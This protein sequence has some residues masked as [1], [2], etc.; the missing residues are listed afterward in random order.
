MLNRRKSI[1]CMIII[2]MVLSMGTP[3]LALDDKEQNLSIDDF[4][5][6]GPLELT[7]QSDGSFKESAVYEI[8]YDDNGTERVSNGSKIS[9]I[10]GSGASYFDISYDKKSIICIN[11]DQVTDNT[12]IDISMI[13]DETTWGALKQN[14]RIIKEATVDNPFIVETNL[15]NDTFYM[16]VDGASFGIYLSNPKTEHYMKVPDAAKISIEGIA[17]DDIE[18]QDGYKD[19]IY[20]TIEIK[21]I[22]NRGEYTLK[23]DLTEVDGFGYVVEKKMICNIPENA[24]LVK[25]DSQSISLGRGDTLKFKI[26]ATDGDGKI[27]DVPSDISFIIKKDNGDGDV[28]DSNLYEITDLGDSLYSIQIKDSYEVNI[29]DDRDVKILLTSESK[30]LSGE[31]GQISIYETDTIIGK[32]TIEIDS[33]SNEK[34]YETYELKLATRFEL[35][36]PNLKGWSISTDNDN[37]KIFEQSDKQC[38]L[39]INP[40]GLESTTIK[41]SVLAESEEYRERSSGDIEKEIK[42]VVDGK[43][44]VI[45]SEIFKLLAPE[46]IDLTEGNDFSQVIPLQATNDGKIIIVSES[47]YELEL[48]EVTGLN[49]GSKTEDFVQVEGSTLK[50]KKETSNGATIK[51][52]V[53]PPEGMPEELRAELEKTLKTIIIKN[54]ENTDSDREEPNEDSSDDDKSDDNKTPS[55]GSGGGGGGNSSSKSKETSKENSAKQDKEDI[56]KSIKNNDKKDKPAQ[57]EVNSDGNKDKLATVVKEVVEKLVEAKKDLDVKNNDLVVSIPKETLEAIELKEKEVIDIKINKL[58]KKKEEV[59]DVEGLKSVED[60]SI[61]FEMKKVSLKEK[62]KTETIETVKEPVKVTL[63]LDESNIANMD[64]NKL[65]AVVKVN[66][67][68]K[69]IGGTYNEKD[70]TFTFYADKTAEYR[71]AEAKEIRRINLTIDHYIAVDEKKPVKLDVA[72]KINNDDRTMVPIRFI[73]EALGSEV[74]WDYDT[75]TVTMND[76]ERELIIA[77]GK[78]GKGLDTPPVIENGRTLVPLRYV[79]EELGANVMWFSS[80]QRI[81]IVK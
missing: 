17:Q 8:V 46:T 52:K 47:K 57:L 1:L 20:K 60:T 19:G 49:E 32:D 39:E 56:E 3:V 80:K 40:N 44:P 16:E 6:K 5:V 51:I 31:S 65:T 74:D 79:S 66:G 58:E 30:S 48:V 12:S 75:K 35:E 64:K 55:T 68:M 62:D 18:I 78:T 7:L 11:P 76:G 41:L 21:K 9:D 23:V 24:I 22:Q 26:A 72:P 25:N 2:C 38:K 36:S 42:I 43:E 13:S 15:I 29:L 4:Y 27:I 70:N 34:I 59:K 10:G 69:K 37:V 81:D 14:I 45:E 50:V 77:I 61:K 33:N 54:I 53:A 73:A 28:V 71:V 67:E 63:K